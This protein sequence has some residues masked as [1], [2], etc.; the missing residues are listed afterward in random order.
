MLGSEPLQELTARLQGP[1]L[2][3]DS[4]IQASSSLAI[5]RALMMV[6]SLLRL[7]WRSPALLR[8]DDLINRM[9][10]HLLIPDLLADESRPATCAPAKDYVINDLV[11]WIRF[12]LHRPICLSDLERYSQLSRRTLQYTWRQRFG[13]SPMQW[14]KKQRMEAACRE[15]HDKHPTESI[16]AIAA[17]CGYHNLAA[18]SR[19]FRNHYGVPPS[20]YAGV[21]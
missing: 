20:H 6:E 17:H 19:D 4:S 7:D 5:K 16:T 13:L 21:K 18:F 11:A 15:L 3:G 8:C 2:V 1:R 9:I 10:L 14:L 12:N